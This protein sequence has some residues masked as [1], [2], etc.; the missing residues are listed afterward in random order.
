MLTRER[1]KLLSQSLESLYAHTN[2]EDF[3]LTIVEDGG[4]DFRAINLTQKY[5]LKANCQVVRVAGSSHI[6]SRL[7]NL[8]V[9]ASEALFGRGEFLYL[10]DNDVYFKDGWLNSLSQTYKSIFSNG[11]RLLGGQIH[12]SHQPKPGGIQGTLFDEMSASRIIEYAILDGPSWFM[13]WSTWDRCGCLP[14]DTAPGVCQSEEYPFCEE[15]IR[16]GYRIGVIEP[17]VVIHTGLTNTYG[18]PAPGKEERLK[19]AVDGVIYE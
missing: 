3:N 1:Y 7:K 8:G 19:R 2:V 13:E 5:S 11:F 10:S 14:P 17:H 4:K 15:L 18:K 9:A 12:P 6:L 16:I